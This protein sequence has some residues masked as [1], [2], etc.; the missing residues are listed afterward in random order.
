MLVFVKHV[1]GIHETDQPH[2]TQGVRGNTP[3]RA[4]STQTARVTLAIRYK[5]G[6]SLLDWRPISYRRRE[7][8]PR[9]VA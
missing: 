3:A 1:F 2:K 7:S 9:P 5:K 4:V 6:A 8:N